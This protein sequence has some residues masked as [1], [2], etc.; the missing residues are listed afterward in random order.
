MRLDAATQ[1]HLELVETERARERRGSL[2]AALDRT[3]TPMGRRMLRGWLLRP[4]TD[5]GKIAVRQRIIAELVA[6][7]PLRAGLAAAPGT[8]PTWSAW[9]GAPPAARPPSTIY[10][11]WPPWPPPARRWA[12]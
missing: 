12:R 4:L 2:L 7:A 3:V 11:P 5:L 6:D 8:S 1:R 9:P 10:A